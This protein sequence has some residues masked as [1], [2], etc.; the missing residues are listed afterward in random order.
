MTIRHKRKSLLLSAASC[1]LLSGAAC[2]AFVDF[3]NA[4]TS[5]PPEL[6]VVIQNKNRFAQRGTETLANV[7][8]G[9]VV[10]DLGMLSGCWGAYYRSTFLGLP[11]TGYEAFSFDPAS[12]TARYFILQGGSALVV[13]EFSFSVVANDRIRIRQRLL[14]GTERKVDALMTL[15]GSELKLA[16]LSQG[17]NKLDGSSGDPEDER[18]ALVFRAF[19]C[20]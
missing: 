6:A 10:D 15:S 12:G 17:G 7:D 11:F 2:E 16:Y 14:D 19:D 13:Q 3:G 8:A 9:E 5:V 1:L 18:V 4:P 20:P